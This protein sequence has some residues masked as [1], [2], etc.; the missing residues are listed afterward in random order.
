MWAEEE[1]WFI[2]GVTLEMSSRQLE[3]RMGPWAQEKC[4]LLWKTMPVGK[5]R[6]Q[7]HHPGGHQPVRGRREAHRG[8]WWSWQAGEQEG[9][10]SFKQEGR[11]ASKILKK[12]RGRRTRKEAWA[13]RSCWGT[14]GLSRQEQILGGTGPTLRKRSS[15]GTADPLLWQRTSTLSRWE[16]RGQ[17]GREANCWVRPEAGQTLDPVATSCWNVDLKKGQGHSEGEILDRAWV[18][19]PALAHW[20]CDLGSLT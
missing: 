15:E 18:W 16:C 20:L 3:I 11:G 2:F 7:G 4:L 17:E 13:G 1:A 10:E 5:L 14:R 9:V 19:A 6:G 8:H 12:E